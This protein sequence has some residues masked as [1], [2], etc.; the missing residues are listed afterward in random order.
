MP[1]QET[2]NLTEAEP[3]E[4]DSSSSSNLSLL[5]DI[6]NVITCSCIS[7]LKMFDINYL[8]N[9]S[10]FKD[11]RTEL[12]E[13]LELVADHI[14]IDLNELTPEEKKDAKDYTSVWKVLTSTKQ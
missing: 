1:K 4:S 5:I 6:N 12:N 11:F 10:K 14:D 7:M 2:K 3:S 9:Q 13:V 8:E